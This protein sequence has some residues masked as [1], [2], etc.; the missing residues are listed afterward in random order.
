QF[1]LAQARRTPRRTAPQEGGHAGQRDNDAAVNQWPPGAA[2]QHD[3]GRVHQV[4]EKIQREGD[5]NDR[6]G[7]A[8]AGAQQDGDLVGQPGA[9][10]GAVSKATPG[11]A[12]GG[13]RVSRRW[14]LDGVSY[15][16]H[17]R[18]TRGINHDDSYGRWEARVR[19]RM[20]SAIV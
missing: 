10:V 16:T 12:G 2:P 13:F 3:G 1:D 4:A 14:G 19:P 17:R 18:D 20:S 6:A 11:L 5:Q 7:Q 8:Q 9:P 15:Q